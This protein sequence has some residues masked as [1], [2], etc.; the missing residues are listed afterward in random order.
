[1]VSVIIVAGGKG[2][3]MGADVPKQFLPINSMPIIMRTIERFSNHPKIGEVIVVLP[4]ELLVYWSTLCK[5]YEFNLKHTLAAGGST[6]FES[7]KNGLTE[8]SEDASIV[9]IHDAVRPFVSDE[10]INKL[11]EKTIEHES[12]VPVVDMIDSVREI[13]GD[14]VSRHIDRSILKRVQTP[15]SFSRKLIDE[16]YCQSFSDKFTDDASVVEALGH[17]ISIVDGESNNIK[18]TTQIDLIIAKGILDKY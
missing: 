7:V 13:G 6:R 4:S 15:Q 9:M 12:V 16:A 2:L 1:M 5:E 11:I 3:R 17:N 10:L 18:I 14:G 8:I